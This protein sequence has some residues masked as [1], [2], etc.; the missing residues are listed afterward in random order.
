MDGS[1]L[2]EIVDFALAE[3]IE[4]LLRLSDGHVRRNSD[5][6]KRLRQEEN[7]V[8]I[9][10][11][12]LRVERR[13]LVLCTNESNTLRAR[14]AELESAAKELETRIIGVVKDRARIH[15]ILSDRDDTINAARAALKS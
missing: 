15:R 13:D 2:K 7:R 10:E 9:A 3:R 12:R 5:L 11:N 8:T 1:K 6:D 14:V 4:H